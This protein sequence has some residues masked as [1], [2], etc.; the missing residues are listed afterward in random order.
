MLINKM[1]DKGGKLWASALQAHGAAQSPG[2]SWENRLLMR[3]VGSSPRLHI[4]WL[5]SSPRLSLLGTPVL[6]ALAAPLFY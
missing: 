1:L 4:V 6:T 2:K 3:A 5:S